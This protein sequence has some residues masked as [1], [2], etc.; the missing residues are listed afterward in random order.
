MKAKMCL[1]LNQVGKTA[2]NNDEVVVVSTCT[3]FLSLNQAIYPYHKA[4]STAEV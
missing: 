4:S 2:N 1:F 3:A